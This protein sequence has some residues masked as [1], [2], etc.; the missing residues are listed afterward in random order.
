LLFN[1]ALEYIIRR[2]QECQE[3]LK[4]NEKHQLLAY[5]TDNIF[6]ENIDTIQKN[7]EALLDASK[8]IGLEVDPEK[9][10]YMLMSRCKKER[11]KQSVKIANMSFEGGAKL[12]YLRTSLTDQNCVNEEIKSRLNSGI[13]DTIRSKVLCLPACCLGT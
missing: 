6:E 3:G 7:T 13:L 8:E 4:L 12:K 11:Q 9:T 2:D 10:K 5:T 1:F